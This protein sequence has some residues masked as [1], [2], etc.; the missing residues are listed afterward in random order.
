MKIALCLVVVCVAFIAGGVMMRVFDNSGVRTLI[1]PDMN[2]PFDVRLEGSTC[3]ITVNSSNLRSG[4]YAICVTDR[5]NSP[6]G[7]SVIAGL[8]VRVKSYDAQGRL[9]DD[10]TLEKAAHVKKQGESS[11][12]FVI[13]EISGGA[14]QKIR[15]VEVAIEGDIVSQGLHVFVSTSPIP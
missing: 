5:T 2:D 9:L 14:A 7:N 12:Y 6:I 4:R 3:A 15:R 13:A 11:G 10:K 8:S 1:F